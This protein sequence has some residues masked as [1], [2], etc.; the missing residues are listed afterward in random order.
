MFSWFLLSSFILNCLPKHS[1]PMV[2]VPAVCAT[3]IWTL[4][5]KRPVFWSKAYT[6]SDG[7]FIAWTQRYR[8]TD[9]CFLEWLTLFVDPGFGS[10]GCK[11]TGLVAA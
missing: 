8:R 7:V 11:L 9:V 4:T 6:L 2:M 3:E 10:H 1:T 5:P